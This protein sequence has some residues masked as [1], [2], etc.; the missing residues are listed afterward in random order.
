MAGETNMICMRAIILP[1]SL[2]SVIGLAVATACTASVGVSPTVTFAA[3]GTCDNSSGYAIVTDDYADYC[4]PSFSCDG[5]YYAL[6]NG[7]AWDSCSC[8][9]PAGY[10]VIADPEFGDGYGGDSLD[11]GV[12]VET[13]SPDATGTETGGDDGGSPTDATGTETG[14]DDGGQAGDT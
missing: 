4:G 8:T 13:G 6:C 5:D 12:S 9:L 1:I 14:G 7:T 2:V 11:G 3:Y 10:V